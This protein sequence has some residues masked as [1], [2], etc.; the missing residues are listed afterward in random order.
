[1]ANERQKVNA[2]GGK[3]NWEEIGEVEGE[4]TITR[5]Y[6]MRQESIFNKREKS[7]YPFL[8]TEMI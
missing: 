5:I 2:S 6:Y 1:M 3:G 7:Q 4:E 8:P